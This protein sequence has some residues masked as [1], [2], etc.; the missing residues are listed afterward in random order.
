MENK[1]KLKLLEIRNHSISNHMRLNKVHPTKATEHETAV[2]NILFT[3][4]M[5]GNYLHLT[6]FNELMYAPATVIAG[7]VKEKTTP[8]NARSEQARKCTWENR[9]L[10]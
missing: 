10:Q 8:K 4:M 3:K 7:Y 1:I 6:E 9:M 5:W 2:A